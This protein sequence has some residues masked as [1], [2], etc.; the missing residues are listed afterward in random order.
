MFG[1]MI[2]FPFFFSFNAIPINQEVS[3]IQDPFATNNNISKPKTSWQIAWQNNGSVICN[4]I[5]GQDYPHLISDDNGG[6]IIIWSD[7]RTG[8]TQHDIYAQKIK[9]NGETLWGNGYELWG[10]EQDRNGTI[11]TDETNTI[12]E[13]YPVICSDNA[14]GAIIAWMDNRGPYNNHEIYAQHI[15]S[16]G[17]CHWGEGGDLNGSTICNATG[18]DDDFFVRICS[19][20]TGGAFIVWQDDRDDSD[21][22]DIYAQHIDSTG[23]THWGENGDLNGTV[24]CNATGDQRFTAYSS[25]TFRNICSD[26]QEGAIITW[27]DQRTSAI[28]Q[29][30]IYAQ[31]IDSSGQ[32]YWGGDND[33]NGTVICNTTAD[34]EFPVICSDNNDGAIIAW[35]KGDVDHQ[36]ISAQLIDGNG[37]TQWDTNGIVISDTANWEVQPQVCSDKR[38]GAYIVWNDNYDIYAQW[39]NSKGVSQWK[40]NGELI[41]NAEITDFMQEMP[42]IC[43]DENGGVFMVWCDRRDNT[44]TE[45][46]I[47]AQYI[48]NPLP[49]GGAPLVGGD[50]D[51]DDEGEGEDTGVFI[52]VVIII[53]FASVAGG[54]VV[55]YVLIQKGIIDISKLKTKLNR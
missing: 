37:Q 55:I 29:C 19:D 5:D 14:G 26:N 3:K 46:D 38:G 41:C 11:I 9:S 12:S 34:E 35:E 18:Q 39:V 33:L 47:Y 7:E 25:Y 54:L 16:S 23:Q 48:S 21:I 40:E 8:G 45:M 27:I 15:D 51:D 24:V 53:V 6:A 49:S 44:A 36:N 30:D 42:Q 2:F 4:Y 43:S 31:R 50:D 10:G 13:M 17:Q 52:I 32:T 22:F 28:T 20:G 1:I